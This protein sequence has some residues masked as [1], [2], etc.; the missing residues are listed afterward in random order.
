MG[1]PDPAPMLDDWAMRGAQE[2]LAQFAFDLG[3]I[4]ADDALARLDRL[5]A[6][7][8]AWVLRQLEDWGPPDR[9]HHRSER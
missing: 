6:A 3:R 2:A 9:R 7:Q 1:T 8:R 5:T 4:D